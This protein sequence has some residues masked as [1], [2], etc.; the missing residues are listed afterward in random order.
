VTSGKQNFSCGLPGCVIV[1][2]RFQGSSISHAP[3]SHAPKQPRTTPPRPSSAQGY[4]VAAKSSLPRRRQRK[5]DLDSGQVWAPIALKSMGGVRETGAWDSGFGDAS[6]AGARVCATRPARPP[7]PCHPGGSWAHDLRPTVSDFGPIGSVA[8]PIRCSPNE[9][10]PAVHPRRAV[11]GFAS[12]SP[13][14]QRSSRMV[15]EI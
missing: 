11:P 3:N 10:G 1:S 8:A 12:Q 7:V 15:T 5:T 2:P 4:A 9:N 14:L 13:R 6:K